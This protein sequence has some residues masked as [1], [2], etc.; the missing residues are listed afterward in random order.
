MQ[1]TGVQSLGWEDPL[2]KEIATHSRT[3]AW[4]VPWTEGPGG[5]QC[6]GSQRVR[7]HLA[8]KQHLVHHV[9]KSRCSQWIPVLLFWGVRVCGLSRFSFVQLFVTPRTVACQ[10]SVSMGFPRQGYWSGFPY[11]PSGDL[12]SPGTEPPSSASAAFQVD[13]LPLS[14]LGSP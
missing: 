9:S 6:T 3:L 4:T 12:P 8:T 5:L 2:K 14:H 1:E 13:S 10:A 11:L 7:S